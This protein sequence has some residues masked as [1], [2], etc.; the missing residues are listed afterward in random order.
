MQLNEAASQSS[1][2]F[3][4]KSGVLKSIIGDV[5][6]CVLDS[7]KLGLLH[8]FQANFHPSAFCRTSTNLRYKPSSFVNSVCVPACTIFPS[9]T[10]KI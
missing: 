1:T 10:T 4:M 5:I 9:S 3:I 6:N 2:S 7:V 8:V